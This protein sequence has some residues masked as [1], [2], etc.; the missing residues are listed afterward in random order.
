MGTSISNMSQ[1]TSIDIATTQIPVIIPDSGSSTGFNNKRIVAALLAG[2]KWYTGSGAPDIDLGSNGDWYF[3]LTT[4]EFYSK[5]AGSWNL[6]F[7]LY[8]VPIG[9]STGQVLAKASGSDHDL[10]WTDQAG[11][12]SIPDFVLQN[13]G[14][15]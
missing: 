10:L 2:T 8:G 3:R 14:I 7:V 4:G 6:V 12:G 5:T 15:I 9:G 11:G 1:A 13:G